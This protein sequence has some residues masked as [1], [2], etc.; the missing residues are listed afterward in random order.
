MRATWQRL[1]PLA[2]GK[3]ADVKAAV[4]ADDSFNTPVK[5]MLG[6]VPQ[7][8]HSD[9]IR[10]HVK[11]LKQQGNIREALTLLQPLVQSQQGKQD[12]QSHAAQADLGIL[13]ANKGELEVQQCTSADIPTLHSCLTCTL[14][15][16]H[17]QSTLLDRVKLSLYAHGTQWRHKS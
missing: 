1:Q 6:S 11:V 13:I 3:I 12:L 16:S 8:V 4:A 5:K 2:A 9:A 14:Y 7:S 17:G 10:G 15:I